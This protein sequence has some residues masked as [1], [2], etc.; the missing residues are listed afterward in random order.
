MVKFY[1]AKRLREIIFLQSVFSKN[2]FLKIFPLTLFYFNLGN[3][4]SWYTLV[5]HDMSKN[6]R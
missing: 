6:E 4:S 3:Y 5:K 1:D 2:T